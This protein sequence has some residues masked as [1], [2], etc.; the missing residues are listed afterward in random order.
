MK[1]PAEQYTA[2][3]RGMG[4]LPQL[5]SPSRRYDPICRTGE[6][7]TP[8]SENRPRQY[9]SALLTAPRMSSSNSSVDGWRAR[10]LA[11]GEAGWAP[12]GSSDPEPTKQAPVA[13][14]TAANRTA[15]LRG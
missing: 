7:R 11:P 6:N 2:L 14:T 8:A 4:S 15:S 10:A 13:N 3:L 12:S 5:T 1:S 9:S